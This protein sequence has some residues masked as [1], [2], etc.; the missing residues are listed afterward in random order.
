MISGMRT[1]DA[2]RRAFLRSLKP[3]LI[4]IQAAVAHDAGRT[5]S[6]AELDADVAAAKAEYRAQKPPRRRVHIALEG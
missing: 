3:R 6:Q 4:Q 5:V 2:E 1:R